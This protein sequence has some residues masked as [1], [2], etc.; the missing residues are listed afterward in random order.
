MSAGNI[1]DPV[2]VAPRLR[3]VAWAKRVNFAGKAAAVLAVA[4]VVT[5]IG[6]YSAVLGL[7]PFG[8]RATIN[9]LFLLL[10]LILV[11]PLCGIIFWRVAQ[12]W[13]ERRRGLA[14]SRLHVRLVLLFGLVAVIPTIIVAI[15]SYLLFSFGVQ[16]WFSDRVRTA[17]SES[18]AVAEA[19]LHEHQ[20]TIRADVASMAADLE[21]DSQFLIMEPSRF[22]QMVTAQAALRS[23][24]E[25]VVFDGEGRI[26]ARS[27]LTASLELEPVPESAMQQANAGNIAVL[28]SDNDDRVR[29]LV[30][31]PQF[32]D[33]YLYVGRFIDPTVIAHMQQTQSAVAQYQKLEGERSQF[34]FA[35]S[36]LFLVV[37]L[38]LLTSAVW[39]GLR[40]ATRMARPITSLVAAAEQVRAGDLTARVPEGDSQDE[41]GSLSRAFNRMTHQLESQRT[42]LVAANRQL[43]ERRRFTETVLAGVSAGVIGLDQAGRINLPN[44]SASLLLAT[45]LDLC[46]GQELIGVVPEM[47]GLFEEA[48]RRPE[49]LAQAQIELTRHHR[50]QTL[51]VR[52][53]AER[54]EGE[55]KGFIVTF[56]DI[57]EL[58]SAQRKAAWADVARRIAHEIKNPLTPIQLS[59]ERLKRKYLRDIANDPQTFADCT[60][61]IIRHVGDIG[62]MVDEFSSFA[63]MP[64]P[65]IKEENVVELVRQAVFLQRT[66]TPEIHFTVE[67]PDRVP[68]ACDARQVSQ[69]LVNILKNAAES[70]QGRDDA[71]APGEIA[72]AV[73]AEPNQVAVSI[74]DNGRGL[75]AEGRE[76]LTEPYVTT[77]AKGTGLGLAIVKKIMEDHRGELLLEDREGGGARVRLLFNRGTVAVEETKPAMKAAAH[78]A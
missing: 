75:P 32:G 62:R 63:R 47:A 71:T 30:K 2:R 54:E 44:R 36:V 76:R 14:G 49:R 42:E 4:A 72:V 67:L 53:A 16:A 38:L 52:I 61:T 9:Q 40:F 17:L 56:D 68:L 78:G 77:R 21:R 64:A 31:L 18:L 60:D 51:L 70:I 41:F 23:L 29:A 25:A 26:L 66:S 8:N 6:T 33:V 50:S 65:L 7:P 58:V 24:T 55:V 37:G 74:A 59:A 45:D 22:G 46:I 57:T 27:G 20:N 15:F 73:T 28:T 13:A 34:Q 3:F 43:D 12:V 1:T 11:L 69:A 48:K 19:Y 10:N 39:V 35:L 5:G